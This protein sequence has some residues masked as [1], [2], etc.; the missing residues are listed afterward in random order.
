MDALRAD[1]VSLLLARQLPGAIRAY[2]KQVDESTEEQLPADRVVRIEQLEPLGLA[3]QMYC[4]FLR[5][6]ECD[7][8]DVDRIVSAAWRTLELTPEVR[9]D[10][11]TQ[12]RDL[13]RRMREFPAFHA[14][15]TAEEMV[16]ERC[17]SIQPLM[18]QAPE[19]R[20][21]V[22][23]VSACFDRLQQFVIV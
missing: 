8:P 12:A 16:M 17:G 21:Y 22:R 5:A 13:F 2:Y 20:D 3:I 18:A 6:L 1:R 14:N 19:L 23:S 15:A 11:V 9:Q 10:V 7:Q 4:V